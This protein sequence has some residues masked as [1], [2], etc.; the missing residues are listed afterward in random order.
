MGELLHATLLLRATF[1][2]LKYNLQWYSRRVVTVCGYYQTLKCSNS[3]G[4]RHRD[5]LKGDYV[6][7]N[8]SD[9]H[10]VRTKKREQD[11]REEVI[12][13]RIAQVQE[14][15][16]FTLTN[17]QQKGEQYE[18]SYAYMPCV[19]NWYFRGKRCFGGGG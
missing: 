12:T 9:V 7:E 16:H 11:T 17:N 3:S 5:C 15:C 18:K 14:S 19:A 13:S 2:Q 6:P 4:V 10:V 1:C 8:Q